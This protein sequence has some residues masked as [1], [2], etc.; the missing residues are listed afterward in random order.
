[1]R[2]SSKQDLLNKE[3]SN[4]WETLKEM[5]NLLI[6]L[7]PVRMAKILN[8]ISGSSRWQ[9]WRTRANTPPLLLGV[10]T[11]TVT[12]EINME[13]PQESE[14]QSTSR[15]SYTTLGK[16]PKGQSIL[17]QGNLLNHIHCALFVIAISW[18]WPGRPSTEEWIKKLWYIYTMEIVLNC[19]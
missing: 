15:P 9:R 4:I 10:H 18:K 7:T 1:M 19:L 6:H 16:T 2:N 13:A 3:I 11:C 14:N 8:K 12:K 5:F 17:P